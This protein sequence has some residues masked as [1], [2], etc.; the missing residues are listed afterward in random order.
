MECRVEARRWKFDFWRRAE[1]RF[2]FSF[3]VYEDGVCTPISLPW[4]SVTLMDF[5]CGSRRSECERVTSSEHLHYEAGSNVDVHIIG[6]LLRSRTI[7]RMQKGLVLSLEV[8]DPDQIEVTPVSV[9][10]RATD[11]GTT[12]NGC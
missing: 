2:E 7:S 9:M 1:A 6:P 8:A 10:I 11:F 3:E 5:D 4:L 12:L